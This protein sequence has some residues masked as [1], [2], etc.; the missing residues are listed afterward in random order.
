MQ[1]ISL[2]T[3]S[4]KALQKNKITTIIKQFVTLISFLSC[5]RSYK[6]G[7]KHLF[8][9]LMNSLNS[10][11]GGMIELLPGVLLKIVRGRQ[12]TFIKGR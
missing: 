11:E 12:I 6:L 2:S 4:G 3:I 5:T 1:F 9:Q 10:R 7:I 8:E